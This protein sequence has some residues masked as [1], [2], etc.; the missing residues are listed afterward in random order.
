LITL[1]GGFNSQADNTKI[2]V[3]RFLPTGGKEVITLDLTKPSDQRMGT[4]SGDTVTVLKKS[5]ELT[6]YVKLEGDI[7]QPGYRQ[8]RPKQ[9]VAD[10]F[11]DIN[12]SFNSSADVNY[13][14]LVREVNHQRDI[15]VHQ[16]DIAAAILMPNGKENKE[17]KPRDKI[18]VFNRFD[19][20]ELEQVLSRKTTVLNTDDEK[21]V[22][23][24]YDEA[25]D[26][27]SQDEQEIKQQKQTSVVQTLEASTQTAPSVSPDNEKLLYRGIEVT[28]KDIE[29]LRA[30]TRQALLA[31][32]FLKLQ[33]QSR[34]D[35]PPLI[36]EVVG[37]VKYPGRYPISV[38]MTVS[39]LVKAAGGLTFDA[40]TINAELAHSIV[41]KRDERVRTA[42]TRV[43][44]RR[45]L[46]KDAQSDIQ[47]AGRDRLNI[48]EKPAAKLQ[49]TVILQGEVHFPGTY[50]VHRGETMR[51]VIQRAGGLTAYANPEGAIFT[52][53]AL[54]LQEKKLLEQ[55]AADIRKE[56]AKKTFRADSNLS[57]V[58]SNPDK[59]LRFIE[60][61]SNS[62]ALGRMVIQLG[63]ILHGGKGADFV[64]EDGD[65]LFVPT[66][67]NTVSVMGEVQVPITYLLE[68]KLDADDYLEKAGGMKKQAD[69]DRIFVVRA[70]GSVYKPKTGY[71][72]GRN[73]QK[74][75]AG[76][77][78]VVP[79]DTDYRDGLSTWSAATQIMYQVGVAIN[80]LRP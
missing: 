39:A 33:E 35:A 62:Q 20:R 29:R 67:R 70:N 54:R 7:V 43:D 18:I 53:E 5:A 58:I 76:D 13:A 4:K 79:I 25:M 57:S 9:R 26:Q 38:G 61:V 17:L 66:F 74:L 52:R 24:S 72:F 46:N 15:E 75:Q 55:Y 31:P 6:N 37:E 42:I 32:I 2:E 80:A 41:N 19:P 21:E 51:E 48:L 40:Y 49:N 11:S 77:T 47:I 60:E 36:T 73:K 56:T 10:L 34:S 16:I 8:W 28:R 12:S 64:L 27:A 68:E 50:T 3:K 44:L 65:F 14:L 45:A 30:N 63:R 1:A 59:T 78:I 22:A 69:K 23:K 71:W